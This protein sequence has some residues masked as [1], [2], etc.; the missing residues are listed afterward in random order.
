MEG[1]KAGTT[2]E[3]GDRVTC[4]TGKD[5]PR[6]VGTIRFAGLTDFAEGEWYGVELDEPKGK[7]NGSVKERSYFECRELH[8][9]FLRQGAIHHYDPDN[10]DK[11]PSAKKRLSTR[12]RGSLSSK[13]PSQS[14][15]P[16]SQPASPPT[17]PSEERRSNGKT[18]AAGY[19]EQ[20]RRYQELEAV[21]TAVQALV[22]T[23]QS[24]EEKAVRLDKSVR[25]KEATVDGN[26]LAAARAA[27]AAGERGASP[28]EKVFVE[29]WLQG[30]GDRLR[31]TMAEELKNRA[32]VVIS[33][34]VA[35]GTRELAE[36]SDKVRPPEL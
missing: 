10:P 24:V 13:N 27:V 33:K 36:A 3:V 29:R 22:Q 5:V 21:R 18:N 7:N 6:E 30:V 35:Q 12:S 16:G 28:S 4:L 26:V 8:G 14:K 2:F 23:V 9:L 31:E 25:E 19:E 32:E 17:S 34:A 1:K 15:S 20:K 11:K